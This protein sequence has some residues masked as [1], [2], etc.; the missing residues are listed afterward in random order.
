MV[1][2]V[3]AVALY[4]AVGCG[5]SRAPRPATDETDV[6]TVTVSNHYKLNAVIYDV[7]RGGRRR[8]G[9]V[10]AA[11]SATFRLHLRQVVAN[12]IQLYADPVGDPVGVH[13]EVLRLSPGDEVVWTLESDL[14]RSHAEIRL[15]RR[16]HPSVDEN[17]GRGHANRLLSMSSR[18]SAYPRHASASAR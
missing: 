5:Q 6:V 10:T 7:L 17:R 16:Q 11:S 12:E 3:G 9:D 18:R 1:R 4:A 8:L 14:A 2:L 15:T 13:S